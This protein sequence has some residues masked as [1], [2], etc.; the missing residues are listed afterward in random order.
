MLGLCH[1]RIF[2]LSMNGDKLE[3][4]NIAGTKYL[5]FELADGLF[6]TG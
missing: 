6:I 5:A 1:K 3:P 4:E 2:N